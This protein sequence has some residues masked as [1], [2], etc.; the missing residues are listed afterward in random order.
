M[1]VPSASKDEGFIPSA[2]VMRTRGDMY[3]QIAL[4][5]FLLK[6]V[7]AGIIYSQNILARILKYF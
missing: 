3:L 2:R 5:K 1:I 7:A 6:S 4:T